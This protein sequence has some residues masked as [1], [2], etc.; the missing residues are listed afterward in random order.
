MRIQSLYFHLLLHFLRYGA[1]QLFIHNTHVKLNYMLFAHVIIKK[2]EKKNILRD[3]KRP[4]NSE[5]I[6]ISLH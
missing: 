2:R 1:F 5:F 4:E 6:V 3:F